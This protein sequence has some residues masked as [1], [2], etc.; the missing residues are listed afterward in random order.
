VRQVLLEGRA[1]HIFPCRADK[2]PACKHGFDDAVADQAGIDRLWSAVW[3]R[4]RPTALIG[5]PT[6]V[7][8]GIAVIDIDPRRGGDK[9]FFENRDRLPKTR[10]HESQ[11]FG[12]HLIYRN[13][14]GLRSTKDQIAPG[15]EVKADGGYVIWWPSHGCRVLCEGPVAEFPRWLADELVTRVISTASATNGKWGDATLMA[16]AETTKPLPRNLY[17]QVLKLVP[18][19]TSITRRDQRRVCGWLSGVVHAEKG[20][21]NDWVFW[22]ACRFSEFVAEGRLRPEVAERLLFTAA[23]DLASDDGAGSVRATIAS[24]L[25]TG[26]AINVASPPFLDEGA[27]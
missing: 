3:P 13:L 4:N 17:F 10:T 12:Q 9:W 2:K 5:V 7:I 1:L 11:S 26:S 21:R 6:G 20:S 8:S 23:S 15:V 27:A 25:R 16:G 19:S 22:A 14:P 18:L 24:G